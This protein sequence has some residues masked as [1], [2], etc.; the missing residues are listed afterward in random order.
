MM[1]G[2]ADELNQHNYY[3]HVLDD[4][5]IS[6]SEYDQKLQALIKL[7]QEYPQNVLPDSPTQRVGAKVS[8]NFNVISHTV[9]M[10]SLENVFTDEDLRQ[11]I[12]RIMKTYRGKL[13][14]VC[15][16]KM[17]GVA[18]SLN[19]EDGLLIS[20][21]TRGDG[22]EGEEVTHTVKTIETIPLR[23]REEA[24]GRVEVRGEIFM[25]KE[26]LAQL[27]RLCQQRGVKS[28]ANCR[29][30]AAGSI[31]QQD[32]K[33][34]AER[35]LKCFVYSLV[36]EVSV[37]SQ[38]EALEKLKAWGFL[39][40]PWVQVVNS[41]E[42]LI[43][44]YERILEKRPKLPYE[45]DGVVY[46]VDSFEVQQLLGVS[47]KSPKWACAH[48]FPSEQ[49]TTKVNAIHFQVGRTG[50]ITPVA[51]LEPVQVGGVCVSHASLHNF[52]E[53]ERKDIRVGDTVFIQ[54][55]GDVIPEVVSVVV[56]DRPHQAEKI[57]MPREC[58]VCGG[59]VV[60]LEEEA[61]LRCVA[62]V[63]C[64]A[65]LKGAIEHFASRNALDID[66]LGIRTVDMLVDFGLVKDLSDLYKLSLL[67]LNQLP[68]FAAKSSSKLLSAIDKSKGISFDRFLYGLGIRGVGAATA[69]AL[70]GVYRDVGSLS[71]A[72]VASLEE[73]PDI[74]PIV[75]NHIDHYFKSDAVI[76]MLL[77][78]ERLGVR[79]TSVEKKETMSGVF[80]GF[81]FV[82]TGTLKGM[83]RSEAVGKVESLGGK[84]VKSLTSE[85]THVVA[86][87]KPGSKLAK[88]QSKGL[89]IWSGA[90]LNGF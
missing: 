5:R 65:Q 29:N 3:Y 63:L 34:T 32:A 30:A 26:G 79:P 52:E 19:Y 40:N 73:L 51:H 74:G 70:S 76:S 81:V 25:E 39:V 64:K 46:K 89:V 45:I 43:Q 80:S 85:V 37:G 58:P 82:F 44:Y 60:K 69:A 67:D 66:G 48:K 35:P 55:A 36:S 14:W 61:I 83:S 88:A 49:A 71:Q 31:R 28:F 57:T 2:L 33:I 59:E 18:I 68:G 77:E 16:P 17:D 78:L 62:G 11:F 38:F 20:A 4:P 50:A 23:L 13:Q 72:S 47:I 21:V 10:L 56:A 90:E 9:P 54:R 86:G 8:S 1:Q 6:D 15:E 42:G 84:V 53:V 12:S 7:E 22:V 27:N 24:K 75:A 41:E 87:E